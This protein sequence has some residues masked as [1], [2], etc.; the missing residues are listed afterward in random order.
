MK[1]FPAKMIILLLLTTMV[2]CAVIISTVDFPSKKI[3]NDTPT[4]PSMVESLPVIDMVITWGGS[5]NDKIRSAL[6]KQWL[7]N[8]GLSTDT[9]PVVDYGELAWNIQSTKQN[10]PWIR[11]IFVVKPKESVPNF[12]MPSNVVLIDDDT[13]VNPKDAPVFN[14]HAIEA[15]LDRIPGLAE[16]FVY[17]CDD[18]TFNNPTPPSFFFTDKIDPAK[19]KGM[20][21]PVI[22]YLKKK[23][24][25]G[26]TIHDAAWRNNNVILR[27]KLGA[28]TTY[29]P[30]HQMV[31]LRKSF[32]VLCREIFE[33]EWQKT[34]SAKFRSKLDIHPVG[35]VIN[36]IVHDNMGL[37][38][39]Y[40]PDSCLYLTSSSLVWNRIQWNYFILTDK[41]NKAKLICVNDKTKKYNRRIH[42]WLQKNV[43]SN[44]TEKKKNS[45]NFNE[46]KQVTFV[47]SERVQNLSPK[48][49]WLQ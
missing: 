33:E 11:T 34:A 39:C 8:L 41:L 16:F 4:L 14:S 10:A 42:K 46:Q 37:F 5:A 7:E 13:L 23:G 26:N 1:Q 40:P 44:V 28:K 43:Y 19:S 47:T 3:F 22:R 35:L 38:D 36:K 15:V 48:Q 32:F 6:R 12:S 30:E 20:H 49:E 21:E 31:M 24:R 9:R 25:N 29:Y 45:N 18:M 17:A 27:Q 2:L